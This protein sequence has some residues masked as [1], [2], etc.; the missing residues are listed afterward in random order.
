MSSG[1][2]ILQQL[3]EF[4]NWQGQDFSRPE[5]LVNQSLDDSESVQVSGIINPFS[6]LITG[7]RGKAI[8]SFPHPQQ[9]LGQTGIAFDRSNIKAWH[10]QICPEQKLDRMIL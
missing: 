1:A 3:L 4:A 5:S 10:S 7:R 8:P 6:V 2:G 9:I